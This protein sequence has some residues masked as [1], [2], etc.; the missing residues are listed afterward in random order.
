MYYIEI[1][2]VGFT[3]GPATVERICD[4][5]NSVY[6]YVCSKNRSLELRVLNNGNIKIGPIEKKKK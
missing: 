5:K 2:T 3:Y 4:D 6:L 1:T